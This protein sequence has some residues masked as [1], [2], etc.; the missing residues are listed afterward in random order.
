MRYT[1]EP[2]SRRDVMNRYPACA[3]AQSAFFICKLFKIND[4]VFFEYRRNEEMWRNGKMIKKV[5]SSLIKGVE[6]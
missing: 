2:Q 5:L 1:D 6:S 4:I 3:F